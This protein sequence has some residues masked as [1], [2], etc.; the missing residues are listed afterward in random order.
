MVADIFPEYWQQAKAVPWQI[1][2]KFEIGHQEIRAAMSRLVESMASY[3]NHCFCIFIDGL[4]EYDDCTDEGDYRDLVE[5]L[6]AWTEAL[7]LSMKLCVSSREHNVFMDAFSSSQRL[8][9]HELTRYDM[10]AY[11][12]TRLDGTGKSYKLAKLVESIVER[13]QGIFLWVALVVK[14]MRDQLGDG[15]DLDELDMAID[16]L[17]DD[18]EKLYG[19]ILGSLSKQNRRKAYQT[20]TMLP[21]AIDY[22]LRPSLATYS[23]FDLY[24]KDAEFAE[25]DAF[26][27][28]ARKFKK[29]E[30]TELGRKRLDGW[31][32]GLVET[33]STYNDLS[34][35]VDYAHRSIPEF[36]DDPN[37]KAKIKALLGDFEPAN[38]LS[39]LT[40]VEARLR[41]PGENLLPRFTW[42]VHMRH[43]HGLDR[44]PFSFL[45]CVDSLV[46]DFD[47]EIDNGSF[48]G[49]I[50]LF[51]ASK[52]NHRYHDV[53]LA[54]TIM[55]FGN[56]PAVAPRPFREKNHPGCYRTAD[57]L[58]M[59]ASYSTLYAC[60]Y[61]GHH[62]YPLWRIANDPTVTDTTAKAV[63]LAYASFRSEDSTTILNNLLQRKVLT[64]ETSTVLAPIYRMVRYGRTLWT[65]NGAES[66]T[67]WQHVLLQMFWAGLFSEP[68]LS[69][70]DAG[71]IK[72]F[73]RH[74]AD[75]RFKATHQ[76]EEKSRYEF[77]ESCGGEAEGQT[78][79]LLGPAGGFADLRVFSLVRYLE[80]LGWLSDADRER[81]KLSAG[82]TG[83]EVERSER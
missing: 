42:V 34:D 6:C 80:A 2:T 59:R 12:R 8:R 54:H 74:G 3:T 31:C 56:L 72:V 27:S 57:G 9:L 37:E 82:E 73:L 20:L 49:R 24:D 7:P 25:R 32:K 63:L 65:G 55:G 48:K 33:I 22:E 36:L 47:P 17:P 52:V 77:G 13:A 45:R 46:E 28:F 50:A 40:L 30:R 35:R 18:L 4:D 41:Q 5:L 70:Q 53:W 68:E 60:A 81:W 38:A 11:A 19:H 39:Q 10:T 15:A 69:L 29:R 1:Q 21:L 83:E 64:P 71:I 14:D 67:I 66:L 79:F 62:E 76:S 75:P 23:Y 43:E 61:Q 78:V 51:R 44:E 58:H 16:L 26:V